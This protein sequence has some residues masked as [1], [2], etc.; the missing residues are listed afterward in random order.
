MFLNKLRKRFVIALLRLENPGKFIIH[1]CSLYSLYAE[2]EERSRPAKESTTPVVEFSKSGDFD[3]I[4][5]LM[6][7]RIFTTVGTEQLSPHPRRI[8]PEGEWD[9]DRR[10]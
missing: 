6:D 7:M 3:S 8:G 10:G 5:Y 9:R 1:S 4:I 2:H